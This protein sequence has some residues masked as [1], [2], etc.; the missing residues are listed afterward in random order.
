[1]T[2][3]LNVDTQLLLNGVWTDAAVYYRDP[4]R[5]TRG[6]SDESSQVDPASCNL[7]LDNRTGIYSPRNPTGPYYGLL[8][9]NTPLRVLTSSTA[10]RYALLAGNTGSAVTTPDAA[11]LDLIEN[12]DM[13]ID[14]DP[15]SWRPGVTYGLARKY[16]KT[17][18]QRSWSWS[19]TDGV[20]QF[21]WTT[22]G[23][24]AT[25]VIKTADAAVPANSG[26]LAL[27]VI[28]DANNGFG[29]STVRFYTGSDIDT[30]TWT[31]VGT[32]QDTVGATSIFASTAP[33]EIGRIG[34]DGFDPYAYRGKLYGFD[35]Y[36]DI[37][38]AGTLVAT[39]RFSPLD[40]GVTSFTSSVGNVWTFAGNAVM[41]NPDARFHGEI[42][43][44]PP[45]WEETGRDI[46]APIAAAGVLRR[47]GQGVSALKSTFRRAVIAAGDAVAYWPMEDGTDATELGS[48]LSGHPPLTFN[49]LGTAV[50]LATYAGF[51]A[52]EPLPEG[53]S[54]NFGAN[55]PNYA[56]VTPAAVLQMRF[57]MH[58]PVA[59]VP[60][61]GIVARV[62]TSGTA[63]RWDLRVDPTNHLRLIAYDGDD[64]QIADSGLVA[65]GGGI[66][67]L[68]LRVSVEL[69]Y[70]GSG[71]D[72]KMVTLQVG[73]TAGS[74]F[75][76]TVAGRSLGKATRV[77]LNNALFDGVAFGHLSLHRQIT[78]IFDLYQELN[79]W[80]GETAPERIM[81]LCREEGI[82]AALVGDTTASVTL[83]A[84]LPATL[85][86]LLREAADADLGILHEPRGFL[87][88]AYRTRASLQSQAATLALNYTAGQLASIE[89]T[90][91][92]QGTRN[93]VTVERTAGGSARA[94]LTTGALSTL[95]PPAGVGRYD[96]KVTVN[97]QR[98]FDLPDHAG[99]RLHLGTVDE[100][101]VPVVG[102]ELAAPS[103]VASA[104]LTTAAQTLD[105]GDKVT[106]AHPPNWL[107]YDAVGQLAQGY[108]ETLTRYQR[109]FDVNCSPSS[110]WDVGIYDATSGP[111]EA[112]YSSD[113][114]TLAAGVT[115]TATSLSVATPNGPLWSSTDAPFGIMVAG[116]RMTVTAVAGAASP[117]TFTVT[118][119]INGVSKPQISGAELRLFKP[120]YYAL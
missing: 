13:R 92:D 1:M 32:Q 14:I 3:P 85:L 115:A 118:R 84:Q 61:E 72:Y 98:D 82:P 97:L 62:F 103:F 19:I 39:A 16:L 87:G 77:V 11:A 4:I 23:T 34:P 83:G 40:S 71:V 58:V 116:E 2:F 114:S 80:T 46:W 105:V 119:S 43:G 9:R 78:S 69:A 67:G 120:A 52:S 27:R 31:Q 12:I 96:E 45:R 73:Q 100:A 35:L 109:T 25:L 79:A 112:R 75:S 54:A 57:L 76:G 37:G 86:D 91:D 113:G 26:R 110:P 59:G 10:T 66:N 55:V 81:R 68:N 95:P 30:I 22:A 47:L 111:G 36:N 104:A 38:L 8:G 94:E 49:P 90:E 44:W 5:I 29:G 64:V 108:T 21:A 17:G 70:N 15:Q 24:S 7:T 28:L 18:E 53:S 99:W 51:K 60:A 101:R 89:P 117:Q 56:L 88:L 65:W 107:S 102:L 6:R 33:L 106:I 93:D 50:R 42:P 74:Q 41:V 63:A 20:M 48:A